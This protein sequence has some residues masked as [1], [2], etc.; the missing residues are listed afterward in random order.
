MNR[1]LVHVLKI[2]SFSS[3]YYFTFSVLSAIW[4]HI[5]RR[6]ISIKGL[7]FRVFLA[8]NTRSHDVLGFDPCTI[9][10]EPIHFAGRQFCT[11]VSFL[12]DTSESGPQGYSNHASPALIGNAVNYR[13]GITTR[14]S[15]LA[16]N[17]ERSC[18]TSSCCVHFDSE[19]TR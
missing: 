18:D 6:F 4:R 17:L 12:L 19:V 16:R 11:T 7:D 5:I 9:Q 3:Y 13:T 14:F 10:C 2:L 1:A 15:Y 8:Y